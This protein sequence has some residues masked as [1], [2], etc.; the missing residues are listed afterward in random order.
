MNYEQ[1]LT[2][3][4]K[5]VLLLLHKFPRTDS[6]LLM[7]IPNFSLELLGRLR[8]LEAIDHHGHLVYITSIGENILE[9]ESNMA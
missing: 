1:K 5:E 2:S 9:K 8:N 7:E 6:E 3:T 4:M